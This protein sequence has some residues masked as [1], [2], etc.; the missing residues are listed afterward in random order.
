[1]SREFV[2]NSLKLLIELDP[3]PATFGHNPRYSL[4]ISLLSNR[5]RLRAIYSDRVLCASRSRGLTKTPSTIAASPARNI[6]V[7]DQDASVCVSGST[8]ANLAD[9]PRQSWG[10]TSVRD[11]SQ[12]NNRG[13][14]SAICPVLR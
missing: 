12:A 4:L 13:A 1:I 2:H 5:G 14:A 3:T 6:R 7:A 9:S 8:A 11:P 10:L